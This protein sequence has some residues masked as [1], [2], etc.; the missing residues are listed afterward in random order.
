MDYLKNLEIPYTGKVFKIED[1]ILKRIIKET[2]KKYK[3]REEDIEREVI[4]IKVLTDGKRKA[5]VFPKDLKVKHKKDDSLEL[6]FF[7]PA[8][9]YAT[10]LLRNIL[11]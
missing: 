5:I 1:D 7:L 2:L 3:I 4:G 6:D 9:S 10:I 11:T 8:G